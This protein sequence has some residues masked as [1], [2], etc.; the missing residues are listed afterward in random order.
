MK[1]LIY[2]LAFVRWTCIILILV[3]F[4]AAGYLMRL[5][6][7]VKNDPRDYLE[8]YYEDDP[9]YQY[10]KRRQ[11]MRRIFLEDVRK[12]KLDLSV[13][14]NTMYYELLSTHAM[15]SIMGDSCWRM[16]NPPMKAR[17]DNTIIGVNG[18]YRLPEQQSVNWNTNTK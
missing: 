5:S 9:I 16:D 17:P 8:I 18:Y 14:Y 10:G 2:F 11:A 1:Y 13:I 15:D 6:Y 12:R 7:I 4:G 3:L